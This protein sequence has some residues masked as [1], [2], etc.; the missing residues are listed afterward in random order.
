VG[1]C[2]SWVI[3]MVIKGHHR[4]IGI[5]IL[6]S[7]YANELT[8]PSL[9]HKKGWR[10]RL[11]VQNLLGASINLPIKKEKEFCFL[12]SIIAFVTYMIIK[13]FILNYDP[14]SEVGTLNGAAA[15]TYQPKKEKEKEVQLLTCIKFL[16][17]G[18]LILYAM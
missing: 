4:Q 16:D 6:F 11:W 9:P 3:R 15:Y 10:V 2:H 12:F 18:C 5:L 14:F 7:V 17:S 8:S 1:F 13:D